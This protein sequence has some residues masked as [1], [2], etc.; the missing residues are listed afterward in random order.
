MTEQ[1]YEPD[2][3]ANDSALHPNKSKSDDIWI[4]IGTESGG[5]ACLTIPIEDLDGDVHFAG[6]NMDTDEEIDEVISMLEES[7]G[8]IAEYKKEF[9]ME[10]GLDPPSN[11]DYPPT[12]EEDD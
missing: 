12:S 1:K 7:K 6:F 5:M 3:T 10:L 9:W 11:D 8:L 2:E 4:N